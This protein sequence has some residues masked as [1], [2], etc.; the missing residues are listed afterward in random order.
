MFECCL[1]ALF[2]Y[3]YDYPFIN[4]MM[5]VALRR[6]IHC[7]SL[8]KAATARLTAVWLAL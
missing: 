8:C 4:A 5:R 3:V 2:F 6:D 1:Y 7:R